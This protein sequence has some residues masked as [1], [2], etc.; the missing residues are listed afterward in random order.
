MDVIHTRVQ[1]LVYIQREGVHPPYV[2]E[3]DIQTL[4]AESSRIHSPND[5]KL[6]SGRV[7]SY[8]VRYVIT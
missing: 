6:V 7:S 1:I 8:T 4:K 2:S 5:E 3:E